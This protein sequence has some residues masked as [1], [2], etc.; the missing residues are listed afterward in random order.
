VH[1]HLRIAD[2]GKLEKVSF[3]GSG[4]SMDACAPRRRIG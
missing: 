3:T 2:D 4:C 1:L